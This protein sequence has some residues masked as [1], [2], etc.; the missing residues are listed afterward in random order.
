VD[1]PRGEGIDLLYSII[2]DEEIWAEGTACAN[3][4]EM[5][6]DGCLMQV[7][8]IDAARGRVV[9]IL[10]TDPEAY[11]HPAFQPGSIVY[12]HHRV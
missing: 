6:I 12:I 5:E 3:F 1:I 4:H 11:L 2:P 9:R 7:E 8:P 10:S